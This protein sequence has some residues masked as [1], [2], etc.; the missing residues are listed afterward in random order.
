MPLSR[1]RRTNVRSSLRL[2][3][4]RDLHTEFVLRVPPIA[5]RKWDSLFW[6]SATPT[7]MRSQLPTIPFVD[8]TLPILIPGRRSGTRRGL[9]P[10]R[11]E[12]ARQTLHVEV[13]GDEPRRESQK[14]SRLH[15]RQRK[16]PACASLM[17]EGFP[18]RLRPAGRPSLVCESFSYSFVERHQKLSGGLADVLPNELFQPFLYFGIL[19]MVLSDIRR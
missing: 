17:S 10:L 7:R 6:R 1:H 4:D 14:P 2:H 8:R 18:G 13:A 3:V 5:T 12:V 19:R 15:H 11:V 16:V 9:S